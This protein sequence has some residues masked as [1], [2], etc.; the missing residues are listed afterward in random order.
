MSYDIDL[1]LPVAGEDP[2]VTAQ[3]DSDIEVPL[4]IEEKQ[5][6]RP[7]MQFSSTRQCTM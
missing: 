7:R 2:L 6:D 3:K 1:Y 5:G 4:S